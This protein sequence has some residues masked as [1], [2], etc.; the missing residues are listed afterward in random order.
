MVGRRRVLAWL[1][2]GLPVAG[3]ASR[4]APA[5]T[6]RM[7][8]VGFLGSASA[9]EWK[10]R[11]RTFRQGLAEA[12]FA[13]GR[14][15]EIVYRWAGGRN[16]ML[17]GLAAELVERNVAVLV[18]LGN[19]SSVLA[20]KAA[21]QRI[22]VVF[23][24]AAD[25]V[26]AGG[27]TNP[28]RPGGNVTGVTTL[29]VEAGPKQLELLRQTVPGARRM[30]LLVNPTN[31]VIADAQ[32]RSLPGVALALG[33]DLTVLEASTDAEFP[34]VFA[35]AVPLQAGALVVGVDTFFNSRSQAMAALAMRH[36]LPTISPYRE[37]A[38]AG[39]L[40]SYGGNVSEASRIAGVYVGRVLGGELPANLPVQQ[41]TRL[42]LVVNRLTEKA[43]GLAVPSDI[44]LQA[45]EVIE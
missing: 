24:M 23:R 18:A 4:P 36:G 7:P 9:A 44:L 6:A 41:A 37:F 28:S 5:Q 35:Q 38:E 34:D 14:N 19:T 12:G 42:E 3:L 33:V 22:P 27:G 31:P 45:D 39:G 1:A 29:G 40:M 2:A 20:L 15:V 13:E 30:L 16:D 11:L 21:T 8:V 17:P 26:Q 10:D 25:P 32:R 43:L